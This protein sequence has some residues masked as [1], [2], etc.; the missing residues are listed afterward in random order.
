MDS[1]YDRI[2]KIEDRIGS[3]FN[4][5]SYRECEKMSR[6]IKE[7]VGNDLIDTDGKEIT[8]SKV[9]SRDWYVS[10]LDSI[11]EH[12]NSAHTIA[13]VSVINEILEVLCDP[14][15]YDIDFELRDNK[16][17]KESEDVE[18]EEEV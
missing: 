2:A 4:Y 7:I 3:E 13:E 11:Q 9:V 1:C 17:I 16:D 15:K 14:E 6:N 5:I 18:D 12:F 8:D 10:L